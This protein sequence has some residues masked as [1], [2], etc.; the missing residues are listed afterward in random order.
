MRLELEFHPNLHYK[1]LTHSSSFGRGTLRRNDHGWRDTTS[2]RA[3]KREMNK[4][5]RRNGKRII[6]E[7]DEIGFDLALYEQL[8]FWVAY[9]FW[10][11]DRYFAQIMVDFL[12]PM[13]SGPGFCHIC[14]GEE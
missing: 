11:D 4:T 8:C 2:Y 9:L 3:E 12:R 13:C 10:I 14:D 1:E 5:R 6:A 7:Y